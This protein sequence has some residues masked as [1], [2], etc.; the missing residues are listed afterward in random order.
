MSASASSAASAPAR[1]PVA[2]VVGG[3]IAGL[4]AALFLRRAGVQARVFEAYPR[5]SDVAGVLGIASNG[6]NVLKSLGLHERLAAC[7][8]GLTAMQFANSQGKILGTTP[9]QGQAKYGVDGVVC[10]RL[11]LHQVLHEACAEQGI[12]ILYS[13]KLADVAESDEGVTATFEDGSS[14][15]GLFLIGADGLR[16]RTRSLLFPDAKL[17]Y[18]GLV[19]LGGGVPLDELTE[20]QRALLPAPGTMRLVLGPVG[21]FGLADFGRDP[22]SG[23]PVCGWWSYVPDSTFRSKEEL[24]ALTPPEL[25]Q[26]LLSVH[27]DW[28]SPI[29]E[30][31]IRATQE[32]APMPIARVSISDLPVLSSWTRGRVLLIGDAAHAIPPSSG[33]GASQALEDAQQ[34]AVLVKAAL[35]AGGLQSTAGISAVFTELQRLRKPRVDKVDQFA[36]QCGDVKVQ[37][38]GPWACW[39]RDTMM[40]M[41]LWFGRNGSPAFDEQMGFRVPGWE[42]LEEPEQQQQK[43]QGAASA[44]AAQ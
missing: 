30:L 8:A 4:T 33:Q 17:E 21:F 19:G 39:F 23:K 10:T 34:L 40:Q 18:T 16:S 25:R 31:I 27:S 11:A 20:E 5:M 35:L 43:Q 1:S 28:S 3:G 37:P 24:A 13:K 36:R 6:M 38:S 14:A 26:L 12:E 41:F 22:D 9:L 2:L 7:A 15:Q 42:T 29:P 32:A 44:A